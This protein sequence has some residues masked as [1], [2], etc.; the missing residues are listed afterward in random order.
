MTVHTPRRPRLLPGG[1]THRVPP[2]APCWVLRIYLPYRQTD[3]GWVV[4]RAMRYTQA[5]ELL[6]KWLERGFQRAEGPGFR[7]RPTATIKPLTPYEL[8]SLVPTA[9]CVEVTVAREDGPAR[10]IRSLPYLD[11]DFAW[12]EV[13]Q[14]HFFGRKDARLISEHAVAIGVE[15]P[16]PEPIGGVA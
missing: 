1:G 6:E 11:W 7:R 2:A 15:L 5:R 9:V 13:L 8:A 12:R 10:P 16:K 3:G 4:S 14:H